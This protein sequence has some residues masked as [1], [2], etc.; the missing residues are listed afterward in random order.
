MKVDLNLFELTLLQKRVQGA[1][2]GGAG[3]RSQIPKLL[4]LYRAGHLKLDELVTKTYRL[5]DINQGY[6]DMADGKN[7]RGV[8]VYSDADY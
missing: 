1:I 8:V 5:E 3:P 7:L 6:R 4:D 2:F